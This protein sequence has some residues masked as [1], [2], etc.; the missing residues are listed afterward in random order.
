MQSA[1]A[2]VLLLLAPSEETHHGRHGNPDDLDGYIARLE[3]SG[4]AAW[5]KPDELVASLGLKAGDTACDVGAG[6][7]YFTLRLARAVGPEGRVLAVDVETKMVET[8]RERLV[9][10]KLTNVTPILSIAEDPLLPAAACDVALVVDTYHH[11]PDGLDYLRRLARALRPAADRERR[12]PQARHAVGRACHRVAREDFRGGGPRGP[13]AGGEDAAALP[14]LV[15][16]FG[17]RTSSARSLRLT[18]SP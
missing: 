2:L 7:G 13:G 1:L 17:H 6:P 15:R 10:A 4:R 3:N 11:F 5:Q 8:L 16:R 18:L 14:V 12:L 9:D